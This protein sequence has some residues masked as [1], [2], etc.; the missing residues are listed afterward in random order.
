MFCYTMATKMTEQD[1]FDSLFQYYAQETDFHWPLLKCV[2][3]VESSMRPN[4]LSSAGAQGLM[5][6]MPR[7]ARVLGVDNPFDPEQSIVGGAKYLQWQYE[8]FP[9]IVN[10]R[11]RLK[12]SLASYNCGRSYVNKAIKLAK[13]GGKDWQKWEVVKQCLKSPKCKVG[14]RRPKYR[15]TIAYVHKITNLY[16]HEKPDEEIP[17]SQ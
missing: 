14:S 7:T 4:A 6:L 12:F 15:Q 17:K 2:A 9:E 10:D 5:Q 11:E 3:L 8:H 16:E 13:K 1:R